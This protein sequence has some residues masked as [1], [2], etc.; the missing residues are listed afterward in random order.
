MKQ[1]LYILLMYGTN[2]CAQEPPV[3][4]Q[5][6]LED[7]VAAEDVVIEENKYQQQLQF[8]WKHRIDLNTVS[9]EELQ[10]IPFLSPLQIDRF[11]RYRHL[12]G[13]LVDVHEL[14]AVPGWHPE[15]IKKLLPYI[16]L[17]DPLSLPEKISARR[18]GSHQL[19]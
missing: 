14:Q 19:L 7:D 18:K 12:L 17:S 11:I 5:Q 13:K 3:I 9:A 8:L 6:Q 1:L 10:V 2:C 4:I 15:L 16:S